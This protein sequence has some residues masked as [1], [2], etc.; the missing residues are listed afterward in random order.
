MTLS[1]C[2]FFFHHSRI[3]HYFLS[4]LPSRDYYVCIYSSTYMWMMM[5]HWKNQI[6]NSFHNLLHYISF[7]S[8]DSRLLLSTLIII[9]N[10]KKWRK[11]STTNFLLQSKIN[12]LYIHPEDVQHI[13]KIF[14]C[15]IFILDDDA[16]QKE[17]DVAK[18]FHALLIFHFPL[19]FH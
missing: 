2:S 18:I 9:I 14:K 17:N 8:S 15:E 7:L 11:S 10:M 1:S 4:S 13:R 6:C 16:L 3:F 5:K 19:L 12:T